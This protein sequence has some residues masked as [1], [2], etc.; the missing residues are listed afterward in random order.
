MLSKP[1]A[2]HS[3]LEELL[4]RKP[5]DAHIHGVLEAAGALAIEHDMSTE[6]A[7][8]IVVYHLIIGGIKCPYELDDE[9]RHGC[10]KVHRAEFA[11]AERA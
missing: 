7:F 3:V 11:A 1:V 10:M 2:E 8:T 6:T 4:D 5:S 9:R